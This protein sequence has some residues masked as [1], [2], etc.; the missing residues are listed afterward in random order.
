MMRW[1]ECGLICSLVIGPIVGAAA[2]DGPVFDRIT[3]KHGLPSNDALCAFED[4]EGYFWVGTKNGLARLE[5]TRV[6]LFQHDRNDST[7]LAHDQV[8]D[9]DQSRSGTIW[10]ATVAGLCRYQPT[11]GDFSTHRIMATGNAAHQANRMV[12][13]LCVGDTL[14]WVVSEDGLYRFDARR[15]S[16]SERIDARATD[17]P[18]GRTM[19][20]NALAWDDA[21]QGV[22]AGSDKGLAF[23]DARTD[24]WTD[25][26]N[27]PPDQWWYRPGRMSAPMLEGRD[28]LWVFD[29]RQFS[30]LRW[31]LVTGDSAH[32]DHLVS[33]RNHFTIQWQAVDADGTHW[34]SAWTHRL[35]HRPAGSAWREV[36][37]STTAPAALRSG[38]V[39]ATLLARSGA[40]WFV[41]DNGISILWPGSAATRIITLEEAGGPISK[42]MHWPGDTL[43]VGTIAGNISLIDLAPGALERKA[44]LTVALNAGGMITDLAARDGRT[45]WIASVNA[46]HVLEPLNGSLMEAPEFV[47]DTVL[48]EHALNVTFIK[49][50]ADER[51]WIGTWSKGLFQHDIATGTTTRSRT[52]GGPYGPLASNMML[53]LLTDRQGRTWVGM[54]D[55][56]G[57]ACLKDGRFEK[58]ED[59]SGAHIGGVVRC[60]AEAPDGRLWLGTHEEGIVVYDPRSRTTRYL[61]RRNGLPGVRVGMI[62]FDRSGT[63]W[64]VTSDGIAVMG[65]GTDVFRT[66]PVPDGLDPYATMPTATEMPDGRIVFAIDHSILVYDPAKDPGQ[67]APPLATVTTFRVNGVLRHEIPLDELGRVPDDRKAITL[68]LGAIGMRPGTVPLFRYRIAHDQP[69]SEIGAAQRIDLFDLPVG[70]NL[71]EVQA[72]VNGVIWGDPPVRIPVKVLPM[73]Y[74]TWW[75]RSLIGAVVLIALAMAFRMYVNGRL[76]AQREVFEREQAILKERMRIAGDMH[77]DMGAGLSALKLKS[78]MALRVEKDPAKREQLSGLARTAGELI[79][80]MRQIIWT[81]NADQTSIEDLVSYTTNYMRGYCEQNDLAPQVVTPVAWP[82]VALTSEQRRNIFLVVK[83]ALHNV[84]KH[85][86][87]RTVRLSMTWQN[88]LIVEILDDGLG[89]PRNSTD[90]M[91]NGLRNMRK[92]MTQLGGTCV[93]GAGSSRTGPRTGTRITCHVPLTG[94]PTN[95]RSIAPSTFQADISGP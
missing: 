93:M 74:A 50:A 24:S 82:K 35:Y 41:T 29:D 59:A 7:S 51:L 42:V 47:D 92:R 85:A 39:T 52:N 76:K 61:N 90:S 73:F 81:M 3:T 5:G 64:V 83:E 21:R 69:W 31:D 9:I 6:R 12:Q 60:I 36:Q 27:A 84:V 65:G 66:L 46:V 16:F 86:D 32:W 78:E 34:L 53:D 87:A 58:Q 62:L 8:N 23:W 55:G 70:D 80:S 72:S 45:A 40:R 75:F 4:L 44:S 63:A 88:G 14:L 79:G 95:Q 71:I 11:S 25:H 38:Q 67:V 22:W 37:A 56:G 19:T 17:G 77:D 49:R 30:L 10:I 1:S 48:R 18:P 28:T 89:L 43:I 91:G 33:E 26:R 57:L 15:N 54:N 13:V 2:Q 20:R 94:P 68:E